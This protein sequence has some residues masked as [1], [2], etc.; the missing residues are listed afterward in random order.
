MKRV[1]VLLVAV[2][3]VTYSCKEENVSNEIQVVT[4]EEMQ[5]LSQLENVQLVDVRTPE[6][7]KE[8]YI[9][10]FQNIN[11]LS[12]TFEKEIEKLDK[13]KPVI[14]YC[15]SGDR[16]AKCAAKMKEKGFIKV[17]ELDGGIAKW[18]FKG[19]DLKTKS[20]P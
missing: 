6:E 13:S 9:T 18:K 5:E 4:A 14:V 1:L 10:D 20:L 15:K 11:Y 2:A 17:Y 3:L 16:S 12:P 19:Y 8:G 7:Y